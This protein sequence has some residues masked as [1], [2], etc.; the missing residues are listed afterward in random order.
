MTFWKAPHHRA[1]KCIDEKLVSRTRMVWSSLA[2]LLMAL[3]IIAHNSHHCDHA[4]VRII[5]ITPL[6]VMDSSQPASLVMPNQYWDKSAHQQSNTGVVVEVAIILCYAKARK[7]WRSGKTSRRIY[8]CGVFVLPRWV[9]MEL[10]L[11]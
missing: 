10:W 2:A 7:I 5:V 1:W 8:V 4:A 3:G 6:L 9:A 11:C